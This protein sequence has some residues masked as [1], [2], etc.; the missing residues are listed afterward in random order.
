MEQEF[1][2][3]N[4]IQF[5]LTDIA[6]SISPWE[7]PEKHLT[8]EKVGHRPRSVGI[9]NIIAGAIFGLGGLILSLATPSTAAIAGWKA[10][11]IIGGISVVRTILGTVSIIGGIYALKGKCW[12]LA[13]T[14]AIVNLALLIGII[15]VMSAWGTPMLFFTGWVPV[16]VDIVMILILF[17]MN[18]IAITYVITGKKEFISSNSSNSP[19]TGTLRISFGLGILLIGYISYSYNTSD[20]DVF[21]AD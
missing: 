14:G 20:H 11:Y 1:L 7:N 13:F 21:W 16:V 10:A 4:R 2:N 19:L 12:G 8:I 5:R 17:V 6:E 18:I 9:L 3:N 15:P